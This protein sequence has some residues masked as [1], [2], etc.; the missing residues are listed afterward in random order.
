M[1]NN[2]ILSGFK[3]FEQK[4]KNLP[5]VV[6]KEVDLEVKDAGVN[7]EQRA[8]RDAPADQGR[9]RGAILS[10]SRG[11]MKVEIVANVS[12]AAYVEWGTKTKVKVPADIAGYASQFRGGGAGGGNAKEM[13]FAWM[14]RVGIPPERQWFVF[15]SIVTKGISPHP[16]FFIQRAIVEKELFSAINSILNTPH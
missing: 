2:I 11:L 5:S 8:K 7:W 12:Y 14:K 3:E 1:P 6:Q 13:I 16:F 10:A 9:L 15:I 4:L